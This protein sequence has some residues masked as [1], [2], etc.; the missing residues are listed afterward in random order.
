MFR[1]ITTFPLLGMLLALTLACSDKKQNPDSSAAPT[2]SGTETETGS[3][4]SSLDSVS[5]FAQTVHPIV[6]QHCM[7][8]HGDPR[9]QSPFFAVTE[10]EEAHRAVVQGGKVD[11]DFP[12]ASR[13]VKRLTT[14]RHNCWGDCSA[15]GEQ[16]RLA[17]EEWARLL[18]AS[19]ELANRIR[20]Q[21]LSWADAAERPAQTENGTV[22]LQAEH[23]ELSGRMTVA[24]HTRASLGTYLVAPSPP[25]HPGGGQRWGRVGNCQDADYRVRENPRYPAQGDGSIKYAVNLR[26]YV[27]NADGSARIRDDRG[28]NVSLRLFSMLPHNVADENVDADG[29]PHPSDFYAEPRWEP[30]AAT[31]TGVLTADQRQRIIL[32]ALRRALESRDLDDQYSL[33]SGSQV[34]QYL[35]YYVDGITTGWFRQR[36][37]NAD[38]S[39]DDRTFFADVTI[40]PS[41]LYV[42]DTGDQYAS[43]SGEE[44]LPGRARYPI[45]IRAE[46]RYVFWGK[47][48]SAE[49]A[50]GIQVQLENSDGEV[51]PFASTQD[52][53]SRGDCNKIWFG[54]NG[55]EWITPEDNDRRQDGVAYQR[56][57]DLKPGLYTLEVIEMDAGSGVDLVALSNNPEFNPADNLIDEGFISDLRPRVLT[58]D[59]GSL[60]G[61][62]TTF[63]IE[64]S[65]FNDRAYLF[66]NPR[67]ISSRTNVQIKD[68]RIHINGVQAAADATYTRVN[69]VMGTDAEIILPVGMVALKDQGP[70]ADRFSVSFGQ[71][72]ATSE[73]ATRFQHDEP[74]PVENRPCLELEQFS[75]S[76]MPI[77]KSFTLVRKDHYD[78]FIE[79]FPVNDGQ[80]VRAPTRYTCTA[81]HN[82]EHLLFKM[83]EFDDTT[84]CSQALSRVDFGNFE[85]SI[86]LRGVNGSY[87]HPELHFVEDHQLAQDQTY[88][89]KS[90]NGQPILGRNGAP[91]FAG[92]WL[93]RI[94]VY[95]ASDLPT[96]GMSEVDAAFVTGKIGTPKRITFPLDAEGRPI[97]GSDGRYSWETLSPLD[98]RF[99]N[100]SLYTFERSDSG[101]EAFEALKNKYRETI[102]EWMRQEK[103][104]HDAL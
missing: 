68:I 85:R 74:I 63:E 39:R 30:S 77:L 2:A 43:F 75:N 66:R 18:A 25:Q 102:I 86:L 42:A 36:Y 38:G 33:S 20:T 13:V 83:T 24:Q 50:Y 32:P 84:L 76:V 91:L 14:D 94:A 35:E 95:L 48:L 99:D 54:T 101:S 88:P 61:F 52:D 69:R 104:A 78:G 70:A 65:E 11:L 46:G 27:L 3:A 45:N 87:G 81:C 62:P 53:E 15:N 58:F 4:T 29:H 100:T 1:I 71:L 41:R 89:T 49:R 96:A 59:V 56:Y 67:I 5:A 60:V 22:V 8:C 23:G 34:D 93:G 80:V 92:S 72:T 73:P 79:N 16:M 21:E 51:L 44:L 57:W 40:D 17:I 10:V 37:L 82:E 90:Y 12:A 19:T 55:W 28:R 47:M 26:A 31:I 103:A 9:V 6:H 97:A 64:V 7:G 98:A